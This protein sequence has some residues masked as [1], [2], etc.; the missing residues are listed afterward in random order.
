MKSSSG[1]VIFE[2]LVELKTEGV[3]LEILAKGLLFLDVHFGITSAVVSSVDHCVCGV[4]P[5][6]QVMNRMCIES[7]H[8]KPHSCMAVGFK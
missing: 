4:S 5:S 3:A 1:K 6:G 8:G 7:V 2:P